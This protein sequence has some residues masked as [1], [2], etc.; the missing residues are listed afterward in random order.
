MGKASF[1]GSEYL[2]SFL[3]PLGGRVGDRCSLPPIIPVKTSILDCFRKM[4]RVDIRLLVNICNG[5]GYFEDAV[6]GT[7]RD[8]WLRSA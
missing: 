7:D 1:Y 3:P 4:F 8:S 5:P 2:N 6:E